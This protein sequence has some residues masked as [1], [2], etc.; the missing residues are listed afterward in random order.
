MFRKNEKH[1]QTQLFDFRDTLGPNYATFQKTLG[2]KFYQYVF[3]NIDEEQFRPLYSEH[4]SAPN[5]PINMMV[6]ALLW[7]HHNNWTFE[8]LENHILYDLST[9]KAIGS[10]TRLGSMPF[11]IRTLYGFKEKM[12]SYEAQKGENLF[13]KLFDRLT[14]KQVKSLQVNTGIQRCDTVQLQSNI[15]QYSRIE[16]LVEILHRLHRI[17][18][19]TDKA[20]FEELFKP[21]I[22]ESST[23]YTY[24]LRSCSLSE[25]FSAIGV[26]YTQLH[27]ALCDSYG[28]N[29][30]FKLFARVYKE[31]FRLEA[32]LDPHTQTTTLHTHLIAAQDLPSNILQSPDDLEATYRHKKG[33]AFRG[34]V[35]F[36]SET[37]HPDN[38]V[39]LITAV[40]VSANNIDD[41]KLYQAQLAE[42]HARTP[43][44]VEHHFDG[45]FGSSE[46]DKLAEALNITLVQTAIRG[47]KKKQD[48]IEITISNQNDT[49]PTA[50]DQTQTNQN[51]TQPTAED[52]T[53]TNQNDTQPTAEDQTQTNQNDTQPTAEDQTQTNQS[54]IKYIVKCANGQE[55]TVT[56]Q[57]NKKTINAI[58]NLKKCEGCPFA[59]DC[60]T[61]PNRNETKDTATFRFTQQEALKQKRHKNLQKIPP[62]RKHLRAGVE[63]LMKA[64]HAGEKRTGKLRVRGQF[65]TAFYGIAMAIAI[66]FKRIHAFIFL[67]PAIMHSFFALKRQFYA[68][69]SIFNCKSTIIVS[70]NSIYCNIT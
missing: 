6:A 20:T 42:L 54:I 64:F 46:N 63:P 58:F 56:N 14:Q 9:R 35:L 11:T 40:S 62:E 16:F 52:Q 12:A 13:A 68:F 4:K 57:D 65:Q 48:C 2:Y 39:Q 10:D 19:H 31:H 23:N 18:S 25:S 32:Q 3:C 44:L 28:E 38:A 51:D 53:Q 21:Y 29:A 67:K 60:P 43:D 24:R 8:Q 55:V 17:L 15:R 33:E 26:V 27:T 47:P 34:S 50:E 70:F 45:G 49:Q 59:D 66:N 37:C 41:S 5:S 61:K 22:G 36:A 30:Q 7:Q 1:H 69:F